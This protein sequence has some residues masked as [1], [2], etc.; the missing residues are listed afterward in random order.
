MHP[1]R[2]MFHGGLREKVIGVHGCLYEKKET[3]NLAVAEAK[4]TLKVST[5]KGDAA[6]TGI[7]A[8]SLYESKP[9][10]F[11]SNACEEV[12]WKQMTCQVWYRDLQKM[13]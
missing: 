13:A 10:Y 8:L 12:K 1:K 11:M 3:T 5:L 7:I 4:W 6:I 9:F 2:F